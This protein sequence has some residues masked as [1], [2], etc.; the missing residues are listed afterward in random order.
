MK[1]NLDIKKDIEYCLESKKIDLESFC[2][3]AGI[4][5]KTLFNQSLNPSNYKTINKIYDGLYRLGFRVNKIKSE[6]FFENDTNNSIILYHGSKNGINEIYCDGS[7]EDC[8]F[9]KGFYLTKSYQSAL[10][11]IEDFPMPSIYAFRLHLENLN[12]VEL[13]SSIEWMILICYFRKHL[14]ISDVFNDLLVKVKNADI[15]IAPIADNKMFEILNDFL[16]GLITTTQALHAL[17]ASSL[18]K[19]YVIKTQK[20][21]NQL[22]FISNMFPCSEE[23]RASKRNSLERANEIETKLFYAKREYRKQGKYIDEILK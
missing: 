16:K 14:G 4:T 15:I 2:K 9:G 18:G 5:R 7:R 12:V 21:L 3:E 23:K 17:S 6:I 11:F 8:D 20:A 10:S 13:N 19:Q 1:F 22:N